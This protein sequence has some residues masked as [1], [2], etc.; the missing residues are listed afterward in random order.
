MSLPSIKVNVWMD[1]AE[2]ILLGIHQDLKKVREK[3]NVIVLKEK[4]RFRGI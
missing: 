3:V 4:K 1:V 2:Y